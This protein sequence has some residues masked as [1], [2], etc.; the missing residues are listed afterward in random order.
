MRFGFGEGAGFQIALNEDVEESR[1]TTNR[2]GSTVLILDGGK[3]A[4][5]EPLHGFAGVLC[6]TSQVEAI[7]FTH[8]HQVLEGIDLLSGFF[9]LL[10]AGIGHLLN[11]EAVEETLLF[12]DEV[13]HTIERYAAVVTDDAATTI[14]VGQTGDDVAVAGSTDV[15][16]VGREDAV[17][18]G[19]AVFGEDVLCPR[20]QFIAV[21][22]EGVF[23]HAHTAFGEDASLEGSIGLQTHHDFLVLVDIAGAVGR[24][25][26][27]ELRLHIV[28]ALLALHLHHLA[29]FVPKGEGVG[30]R[31]S[32]K[33]FVP[34]VGSVVMLDE[35]T[36]IDFALPDETIES[37]NGIG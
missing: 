9:A 35:V 16:R 36:H 37:I 32:Q 20:I 28:E 19:F 10:D 11:V 21:G 33:S 14:S 2:H 34:F 18:V 7:A 12:F 6:R 1:H 8:L 23:H 30:G 31:C 4:E 26:L 5:I 27:G 25:T 3:I 15:R 29:Q 17:V 22:R 13:V 24:H